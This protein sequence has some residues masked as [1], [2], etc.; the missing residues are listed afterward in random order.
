[1]GNGDKGWEEGDGWEVDPLGEEIE[2]SYGKPNV[3]DPQIFLS[4]P[5]PGTRNPEFRIRI[6]SDKRSRYRIEKQLLRIREYFFRIRIQEA[7]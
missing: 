5:H 2:V 7:N 6:L 1:M 3:V 4:G